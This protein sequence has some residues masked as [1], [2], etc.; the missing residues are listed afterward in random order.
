VA[1]PVT[2]FFPNAGIALLACACV[3]VVFGTATF[4]LDGGDLRAALARVRVGR[5]GGRPAR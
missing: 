2:G 4:A 1:V 3:A 5:P